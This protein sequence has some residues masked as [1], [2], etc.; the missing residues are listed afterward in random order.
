MTVYDREK[1]ICFS[2]LLLTHHLPFLLLVKLLSVSKAGL[3]PDD[4]LAG[5]IN[6]TSS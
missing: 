1:F 6:N 2:R 5:K 3:M 4:L